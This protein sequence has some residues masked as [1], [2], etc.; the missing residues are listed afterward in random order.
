MKKRFLLVAAFL[1]FASTTHA[2]Q[3]NGVNQPDASTLALFHFDEGKGDR[4]ANAAPNGLPLAFTSQKGGVADA[5]PAWAPQPPSLDGGKGKALRIEGK[6]MGFAGPKATA[7]AIEGLD[8]SAGLNVSFWFRA[9]PE[10]SP[11]AVLVLMSTQNP[12]FEI[13]FLVEKFPGIHRYFMVYGKTR[14]SGGKDLLDG[15][16][17]HVALVVAPA[18]TGSTVSFFR[19]G[20]KVEEKAAP[21]PPPG[22]KGILT[23]GGNPFTGP[24]ASFEMDELLV[25]GG[26]LTDFTKPHGR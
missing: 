18:T 4:A 2:F 16:W 14:F 3:W 26:V 11:G 23:V 9:G 19:D 8:P 7:H 6:T 21:E 10:E 22:G 15:D 13:L 5:S 25:Q 1:A 24:G 12:R 17:H 20:E